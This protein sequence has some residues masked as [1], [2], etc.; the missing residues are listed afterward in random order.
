MFFVQVARLEDPG[1]VGRE[2]LLI[3][4]GSADGR[5]VVTSASYEAR[6][7]GVHSAMPTA[8]AL[9]LC[10]DA[11]VVPVP[12]AACVRC[13]REVK[14]VLKGLAPLVQ[15]ASIDE[16]YVDLGGTERLLAPETLHETAKRIRET[17]LEESSVSVSIGGGTTRLIAKLAVRVAKPAGVHIVP[18]GEERVFM[19]GLDLADIPGVGPSLEAKLRSRGLVRVADALAVEEPWLVRWLG[20]ERGR[21]LHDRIRGIDA[22]HVSG[23]EHRKSVSSE[24]TFATDLR[25]HADLERELLRLARTTAAQLRQEGLR[26]RTVTVKLRDADFTT[27]Q[28]SRTLPDPVES[29]AAVFAQA[30]TL[31]LLLR[32]RRNSPVRLLGVA[33]SGLVGRDV[34]RQ[35]E[36]LPKGESSPSVTG[37]CLG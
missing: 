6:R 17:V 27:R 37:A 25:R 1:G 33:L 31:L 2:P 7:F 5:G 12:R 8:E 32:K 28:T 16:F 20:E 26:T 22:S 36:L 9:R 24:R 30:R 14:D 10:P 34:P 3:V 15:A 4:G 13:S 18:P 21:W 19:R 35:L 23:G 29:D 11:V